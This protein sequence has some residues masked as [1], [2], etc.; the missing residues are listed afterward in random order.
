M[1]TKM[2]SL[3][4]PTQDK[5]TD[6]WLARV[7]L[8][9][10]TNAREREVFELSGSGL[11]V[12]IRA[13]GGKSLTVQKAKHGVELRRT[14][15][16]WPQL[17]L[18]AARKAV[19]ALIGRMAAGFDVNQEHRDKIAKA[20]APKPATLAELVDRWEREGLAQQRDSYR[21]RALASVRYT[22]RPMMRTPITDLSGEA[23]EAV[24]DE[25]IKRGP[26]AARMAGISLRTC[27]NWGVSKRAL[28]VAPKFA[29]PEATPERE[30]VLS[31]DELRRMYAAAGTLPAP[32]GQ[33]FRLVMLTGCR[34]TEIGE[35]RWAEVHNLDNP[36]LSEI[37]LPMARTKTHCGHWIPLSAE[38]RRVLLSVP[39][40]SAEF[41][42]SGVGGRTPGKVAFDD[43]HRL[44]A[45]ID[46]AVGAPAL[47]PW[48]IHDLRRSLVTILAGRPYSLNPFVVDKLLGHTMKLRGSGSVYQRQG[49][50]EERIEAL[51][52]W[53][54]V[55]T[56]KTAK[57][58]KLVPLQAK[59]AVA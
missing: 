25:A 53:S 12:R 17:T 3:T 20:K 23:I 39:R 40:T 13:N 8:K 46:G 4:L 41:V 43:W 45:D 11:G 56:G 59:R 38:A 26:A 55:L 9:P 24:L 31:E 58:G 6:S 27:L 44:K 19:E 57:P 5:F 32:R 33:L 36:A 2:E 49:Y 47:A 14:L 1:K 16:A 48:V 37:R 21:K 42:F 30:R 50:P 34:R 22:F 15:G 51:E 10:G 28:A 29:V 18:A 7:Q 35:L 54:Q 52:I